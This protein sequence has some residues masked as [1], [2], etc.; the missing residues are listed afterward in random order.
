MGEAYVICAGETDR[1]ILGAV[2]GNLADLPS[3]R[4]VQ[5]GGR[6]GAVSFARTYLTRPD[7]RVVL[8]CDA[9]TTNQKRIAEER[10]AL[11][12]VLG[13]AGPSERYLVVLAIPEIEAWLFADEHARRL[14]GSDLNWKLEY[15]ARFEPKRVLQE[16]LKCPDSSAY[17]AALSEWLAGVDLSPLA[18]IEPIVKLREFLAAQMAAF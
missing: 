13:L 10:Q 8:V 7:A 6:S 17:P 16:L 9:D 12:G 4:L 11:E 15:Q 14:F 2:L 3:I 18:E 5:G 1:A